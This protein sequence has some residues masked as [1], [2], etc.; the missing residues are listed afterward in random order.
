MIHKNMKILPKIFLGILLS[1]GLA[2]AAAFQ[3]GGLRL[4]ALIVTSSSSTVVLTKSHKQV[5]VSRGS[6]AQVYNLPD[7]T[8]LQAGYWYEFINESTGSLRINNSSSVIITTLATTS[9]PASAASARLYLTSSA[10]TGGP[11]A[12]FNGSGGSGSGSTIRSEVYVDGGNSTGST[13]QLVRIYATVRKNV[14]SDITYAT[15]ATNGDS[16]TINSDGLYCIK[17]QSEQSAG[18]I[19]TIIT[20]N[21]TKLTNS[22]GVNDQSYDA[23]ARCLTGRSADS[24]NSTALCNWCGA[25]SSGDVVRILGNS[26]GCAGDNTIGRCN[27]SVVKMAN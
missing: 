11:W 23:G 16:F 8:T 22:F 3:F 1:T 7:A 24:A 17:A 2:Q 10:T 27:A 20:V 25:L 13:N 19:Y 12:V 15:S 14:G 26:E 6:S 18:S 9:S 4:D 5:N 21:G